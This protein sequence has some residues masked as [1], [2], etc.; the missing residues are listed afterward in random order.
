MSNLLTP[1]DLEAYLQQHAINGEVIYL[2]TPTPTVQTAA[3]AVGVEPGQIIKSLL[4][5]AKDDPVLVI[6]NGTAR[7]EWR[8]LAAYLGI[9]RRKVNMAD[10]A[11]VLELTGYPVGGVPPMG[12][13][14]KFR[15][16]MESGVLDF[17]WVYGG[18]G[19]ETS[20]VRLKTKDLAEHHNAEIVV[21]QAPPEE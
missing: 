19:T 20:L 7:V 21:L 8:M 6:A 4:F 16:I 5:L 10:P 2:D 9:S 12:H 18:G 14:Q 11:T 1:K 13:R 17:E 15:V 3:D